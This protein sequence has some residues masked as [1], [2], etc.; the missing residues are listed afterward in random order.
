MV[1]YICWDFAASL[2]A[3]ELFRCADGTHAAGG[4]LNTVDPLLTVTVA[5]SRVVSI[6]NWFG[7]PITFLAI[8]N[9]ENSCA[10]KYVFGNIIHCFRVLDQYKVKKNSIHFNFLIEKG[11]LLTIWMHSVWKKKLYI[12]YITHTQTPLNGIYIY[13]Y[14]YHI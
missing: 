1:I 3:F 9:V 13:I 4:T 10:A 2:H 8:I 14:I 11:L 5:R 6:T 7:S 12:C